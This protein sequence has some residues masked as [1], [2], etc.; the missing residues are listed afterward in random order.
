MPPN[1]NRVSVRH[2]PMAARSRPPA[3]GGGKG[4]G[5]NPLLVTAPSAGAGT[6]SPEEREKE[7]MELLDKLK[8]ASQ[9]PEQATRRVRSTNNCEYV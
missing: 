3:T 5:S 6:G 2:T 7:M 1:E 4:K 9:A 8:K